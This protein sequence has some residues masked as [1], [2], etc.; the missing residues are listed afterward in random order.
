VVLVVKNLPANA[1]N[2]RDEG[3]LPG[4]EEPLE[5][6]MAAHPSIVA[7]RTP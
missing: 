7:W 6:G 4:W 2:I 3:L 1:R 5:K